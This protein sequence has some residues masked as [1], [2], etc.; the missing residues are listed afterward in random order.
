[1]FPM[2][3]IWGEGGDSFEGGFG[4]DKHNESPIRSVDAQV[5]EGAVAGRVGSSRAPDARPRAFLPTRFVRGGD[6]GT[7]GGKYVEEGR[8]RREDWD[9][10]EYGLEGTNLGGKIWLHFAGYL[11]FGQS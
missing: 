7:E 9:G 2:L 6:G 1:M 4:G 3:G 5:P 8:N 10:R 11:K